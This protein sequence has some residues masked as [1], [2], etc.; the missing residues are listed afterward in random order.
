MKRI[1]S[2]VVLIVLA[3]L[4]P[5][6]A[7]VDTETGGA[8]PDFLEVDD[9]A[10]YRLL[11]LGF[12]PNVG[13][14]DPG[15]E[16][17]LQHQGT[18]VFFTRNGL[19]LVHT[20]GSPDNAPVD[21]IRQSF[22]GASPDTQLTAS[23]QRQGVVNYYVGN[24][25][26][27]W[28]S[29][30]PVY[31][32]VIYEGLYPGIDLVYAEENGRLKRE[33]RISPGADPSQI[34]L[35]YEGESMPHVDGDGVLR[36]A[37]PAGELLESPL[38]C[39]QVIG[40]KRVDRAAEYIADDG[41][42]RIAV[43][44]YDAGHEL[45]I[46]PEL[47][48][49]SYLGGEYWDMGYALAGDGEGGVWVTGYTASP[50]FPV[51][52]DSNGKWSQIAFVSHFSSTGALLSSTCLGGTIT[53]YGHVLAGDGVGGVW[54]M[55]QTVSTDFPV[56]NPSQSDYG[57]GGDT[58]IS[59]FSSDG[60]L[61]SS[62]YL[63]GEN[64]D[65]GSALAGDGT[66]GVWVMGGNQYGGFPVTGG[67]FERGNRG[68]WD[69]FVSH[70]ASNGT[71]LSSTCLGGMN[72]D[73]GS[74]L[75]GDGDGGVWVTGETQSVHVP[76]NPNSGFPVLNAYQ[77]DNEGSYDA[78]VSHFS[79]NGTLLYSTYLGGDER[80]SGYALAIDGAG[81]VWVTGDTRSDNFPTLNAHQSIYGGGSSY[82]DRFVSHFS[83]EGA[84]LSSTYLG[85]EGDDC[86]GGAGREDDHRYTLA[87]D[88][89]GGVWVTGCTKS[90]A[91]PITDDAFQSTYGG[92]DYY[93]AFVSH[94]SS[95]GALL[96]STYL[97]GEDTDYG[98]ALAGDDAGGVWVAGYTGSNDFPVLRAYQSTYSGGSSDA[99]VAKFGIVELPT[100]DFAANVTSGPVPLVVQFT[101]LSTGDPTSWLWSFGDG[102]TSTDQN[103]IHIYTA[104]G[105]YTV[106]LTVSNSAGSDEISITDYITVEHGTIS[107][108][109]PGYGNATIGDEITL[110]GMNNDSA[111]TYLFLTGPGLN[112][113]G[114]NLTD[115]SMPVVNDNPSTFTIRYVEID[116]SWEYLWN[117]QY[118]RGGL[119]EEET[120]TIY[121]VSSPR[122]GA[123][124]SDAVYATTT[125]RFQAPTITAEVSSA[126]VA[127]GDECRITGIAGGAPPN[128]QIWIFGP[129]YYGDYNGALGVWIASVEADGTFDYVLYGTDM[130]QEGQYYV[131]VQHPVDDNFGVMADP[132]TGVI[133][134]EGIANVTLTDLQA[135]DAVTALINALDSPGVDDIYATLNF[136]VIDSAPQANFTANVTAGTMPLT[137]Q[138][139]DT[140]TGDPTA[141]S[142]SF[143]DGN[144]STDQDPVHT[145][146]SPGN[147][148]VALTVS[149]GNAIDTMTKEHYILVQQPLPRAELIFNVNYNRG[150]AND[151]IASGTS[152][153]RLAYLTGVYNPSDNRE[154]ILGNLSFVLDAPEIISTEPAAEI[155]GTRVTWTFPP[156]T[157]IS[158]GMTLSTA[159]TTSVFAPRTSGVTLERS[160][161]RTTFT[162]AGVQQVTLQMT[163]DTVDNLDNLWG[164]I[165]CTGTDD[166]R[167]A[168]APGSIST[169]LPLRSLGEGYAGVQFTI[170]RSAIETGRQYTLSCAVEVDPLRPVTYTPACAVWEVKNSASAVAPEGTTV[171][172]PANLLPKNVNNVVF[173][174]ATPCA[175]SCTLNDHVITSLHQ[176]A[177]PVSMP[178]NASFT[179][180]TTAGVAPLTVRFTDTSSN[181]PT[182]WLWT[183]GD[184]ATSTDQNPIHTYTLP[185]NYTV[186][187]SINGG[188][189]TCT[190]PGYI[191]VTPVLFGDANEDGTVNQADT[192]VVLQEI[193]GL[194]FLE[195]PDPETDPD[196]FRKTDVHAN[197]V[198]EV[199]DALFIAQHNVGLRDVWFEIL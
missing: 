198:I 133:Y 113:T 163:F 121:A 166:V 98:K 95:E 141:W 71:L 105:T 11:S 83:Q 19:V 87:G 58:F 196:R 187:L 144:T 1:L 13:Q 47:V 130:L 124:L 32:R 48:Y 88:G 161:N 179:A 18:T 16:Y 129:D 96:L 70:F 167:P 42:V 81:G 10:N 63:G 110:W 155:D 68:G 174:S 45:I 49:S 183:F 162:E 171:T 164:R 33:F 101:D 39:W 24:D 140:S 9:G 17:V 59:H 199:S 102:A 104:A 62:T 50:D 20:P 78:F 79:S 122:D 128:V 27:E 150:T 131:V 145:Y 132:A 153:C 82:G 38:V 36:F 26:S 52:D 151:T 74:A 186:T 86:D 37:S 107:I 72:Q 66:G 57:G 85:G 53:E 43:A 152:P 29:G 25:S 56:L 147:Y 30:I 188:K 176:R 116:D 118:V 182:S 117:T 41:S 31:S 197:G 157:E 193:V 21:V 143:G 99:F 34:E 40:G 172:L 64:Y 125:V 14:C 54:V 90:T 175:W 142:W 189:E 135:S 159:A 94:F 89:D 139:T 134:G 137:V 44:E 180:D 75:A 22:A 169:D 77:W 149:D 165:E 73:D 120:Y 100:A 127:P 158:P 65:Y 181:N 80:D 55:G 3:A 160:C 60:T 168:I 67:A 69:V 194:G 7:A 170:N 123:H 185:G 177:V 61:L 91:F 15:V 4:L 119:L 108:T 97:G 76:D 2:L 106:S 184:G 46:D 112:A 23:G 195:K 173:S 148:S 156:S 35:L 115:L 154:S 28:L 190:K 136:E 103:P 6:A 8:P 126:T 51:L 12:I 111:T 191:K 192:L 84:L 93:D 109:A 5:A 146:T 178:S 138:F 114:V 92:G